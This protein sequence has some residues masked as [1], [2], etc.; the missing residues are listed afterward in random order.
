MT[1]EEAK[2]IIEPLCLANATFEYF[3]CYGDCNNCKDKH[4][5]KMEK[6]KRLAIKA[7]EEQPVYCN[8]C[9]YYEGVHNVQG[10]AP[11]S[12]WHSGGVL[13]NDYCSHGVREK[14]DEE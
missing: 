12:F 7:L 6:A 3:E 2:K 13:W 10:H 11:C 9:I 14:K 8:Q 1:N 4:A 5:R